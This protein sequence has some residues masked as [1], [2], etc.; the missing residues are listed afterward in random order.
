MINA[1]VTQTDLLNNW[2]WSCRRLLSDLLS[3]FDVTAVQTSIKTSYSIYCAWNFCWSLSLDLATSTEGYHCF[4]H[5]STAR[6][7]RS[8]PSLSGTTSATWIHWRHDHRPW[9]LG[10]ITLDFSYNLIP[11]SLQTMK[12][13]RA[14]TSP[15]GND[16]GSGLER[17]ANDLETLHLASLVSTSY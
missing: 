2:L 9:I 13:F 8:W 6:Q 11:R 7:A 3:C 14:G 10:R 4:R 5:C 1:I 17:W 15:A 16:Y 12:I